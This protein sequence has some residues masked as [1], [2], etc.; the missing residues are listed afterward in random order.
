MYPCSDA[1]PIFLFKEETM[2]KGIVMTE[3]RPLKLLLAF[4]VPMILGNVFQQFYSMV[5]A[6]VVGRFVSKEALASIGATSAILYL[7]ISFIIGFTV[8][9]S[10]V[11]AQFAGAR[12]EAGLK[13]TFATGTWISIIAAVI[14]TVGGNLLARPALHLLG[15]PADIIA[16]AE[17]YLRF[18][19]STCIAPIVYNM[20]AQFLRALGDSKTPLYALVISSLT[21]IVLDLAFVLL[22]DMGVAG[23]ALAT[24]IAQVCSAV[25]CLWRVARH[26]PETL[27]RRDGWRPDGQIVGRVLK[28]GIPMSVQNI[29]V[30]FGMMTIQ[31]MI[32]SFGTNVVA[33]YTAANKVDQIALQFMNS[34]GS[35]MST[36]AGQNYGAKKPERI[37]SGL[38]AGLLL[39]LGTGAFLTLVMVFLGKYIVRLFMD[40]SE[41]EAIAV[42]VQYLT[43]VA[44]FYVL[45][46]VGYVYSN[47]LRGIGRV[48][49]PT[50]AS[51]VELGAKILAAWLLSGLLGS[52]GIWYAWPASWIVT[53]LLLAGYFHLVTAR[54]LRNMA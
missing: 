4:T 1:L 19:F 28:Y 3:G 35:A 9:T 37:F 42:A 29:F 16:D 18:N 7:M 32:N 15:T 21:N 26:F 23:V 11:T 20:I 30:S 50:A 10:L 47:L 36:Y 33:G 31:G 54:Q 6:V 14:L 52:A 17:L 34:I 2:K 45:C 5:D 22:F 38:R 49:V 48:V 51:F 46:G 24:A 13:K 41:A 8:G 53:A 27:P 44:V 12:D 40:A 43:V 25:F 39:T